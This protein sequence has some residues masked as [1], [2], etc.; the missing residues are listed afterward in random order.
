[1]GK[2]VNPMYLGISEEA[3]EVKRKRKHR[4]LYK[5]RGLPISCLSKVLFL[6]WIAF[7]IAMQAYY[8]TR[9][10]AKKKRV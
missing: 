4:R 2:A 8:G 10:W 1:M 7:S 9:P 5:N 6:G 3:I